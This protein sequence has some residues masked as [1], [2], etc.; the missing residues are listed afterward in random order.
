M[1][2]EDDFQPATKNSKISDDIP[3]CTSAMHHCPKCTTIC[4]RRSSL[5]RHLRTFPGDHLQRRAV[6]RMFSV[7][8]VEPNFQRLDVFGGMFI[9]HI[10][11]PPLRMSAH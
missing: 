2:S 8:S 1:D 7:A 6:F 3:Q 9:V 10:K 5:L 11:M 4:G